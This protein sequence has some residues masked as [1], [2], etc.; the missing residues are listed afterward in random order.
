MISPPSAMQA[1]RVRTGRAGTTEPLKDG[2][3]AYVEEIE[4]SS[5]EATRK[6]SISAKQYPFVDESIPND[7]LPFISKGEV[8]EHCKKQ[9]PIDRLL[10]AE[11]TKQENELWIVIDNIIYDCSEFAS[12]HPGGEGV[13]LSFLGEDC[14]W[15]FWRLHSKNVMEQY[16]RALRVGRTEGVKNRFKETV[17]YV[18]L[19]KLGDDNW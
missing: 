14:S 19:S 13:I 4:N 18:G 9:P 12:E 7:A 10:H 6:A 8:L 2:A 11:E 16:G 3:A 15:Q 17:M 5:D 1:V